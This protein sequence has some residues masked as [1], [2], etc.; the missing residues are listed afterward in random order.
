MRILLIFS[1][2]PNA[3]DQIDHIDEIDRTDQRTYRAGL[4]TKSGQGHFGRIKA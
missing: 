4:T 3:T 1:N 2:Y